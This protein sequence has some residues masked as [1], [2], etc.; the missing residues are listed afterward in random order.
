MIL[1]PALEAANLGALDQE[2]K[3]RIFDVAEKAFE[4]YEP[5][6]DKNSKIYR[7]PKGIP[8][9]A[10]GL[11]MPLN[12]QSSFGA[13]LIELYKYRNN[14]KYKNRIDEIYN[15]LSSEFLSADKNDSIIWNY[16]PKEYFEGWSEADDLSENTPSMAKEITPKVEDVSHASLSVLFLMKYKEYFSETSFIEGLGHT[17]E[18]L[19]AGKNKFSGY[20][21]GSL[22]EGHKLLG[23]TNYYNLPSFGWIYLYPESGILDSLYPIWRTTIP[24]G[25]LNSL[26]SFNTN[27]VLQIE[28][29]NYSGR[30]DRRT[31]QITT[32]NLFEIMRDPK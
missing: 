8:F 2:F 13:M 31:R 23:H 30:G 10:D 6:F 19:T 1:T 17:F 27:Q 20:M 28:A 22:L 12:F 4:F 15:K 11:W 3:D 7:F 16:W 26:T 29:I 14:E 24:A 18:A 9:W 32:E 25:Y 5:Y 21:D